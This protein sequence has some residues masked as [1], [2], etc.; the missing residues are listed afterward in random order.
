MARNIICIA[1]GLAM[2]AVMLSGCASQSAAEENSVEASTENQIQRQG[3]DTVISKGR[4]PDE[5]EQ[6]PDEY[7]G[8]TSHPGTLKKLEYETYEA[9][10]YEE[11]SQ[12][13][14]KTAYVYLPY[15]YDESM[16]YPVFY[17]MHGGWSDETTLL[18]TPDE[19][20]EFKNVLDHA[21]E[22]GRIEPMIIVCPTYNNTSGKDSWDDSLA[23]ELTDLY[24]Q[25]LVGDLIPAVDGKY[26]TKASRDYRGFGGFSMGSVATWR[27]FQYCLD[28]FRYFMPM[29]GNA[30]DGSQQDA[31]V[32][33]SGYGPDDFFLFT[34]SG[35]NDFAY[36]SFKAQVMNMGN[37][38][39]DS[40]IFADNEAEGN[41]CFREQEGAVHDYIYAYEYIY[42]GLQFFWSR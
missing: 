27:T 10:S 38:Y 21:M 6:I 8:E 34:A 4:V 13:L 5:L 36:S 19:P 29:S 30:G 28:E 31:A 12:V 7:Y 18:G 1:V 32:K 9:F 40:F 17:L 41:L 15:G 35:T 25:E 14:K 20:T 22:D 42:N 37:R 39:T 3:G 23:I 24:H 33:K 16:Q 26:S 2:T 11:K